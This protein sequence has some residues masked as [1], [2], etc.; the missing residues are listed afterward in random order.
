MKRALLLLLFLFGCIQLIPQNR[1]ESVVIDTPESAVAIAYIDG[2]LLSHP[3]LLQKMQ[4]MNVTAPIGFV[5]SLINSIRLIAFDDG[6]VVVVEPKFPIASSLPTILSIISNITGNNITITEIDYRNFKL[7]T[8]EGGSYFE[9]NNLLYIGNTEKLKLVVDVKNGAKN[10]TEKFKWL[11]GKIPTND[12]MVA[13][14]DV[15]FENITATGAGLNADL[16][17]TQTNHLSAFAFFNETPHQLEFR[18]R[19][20]LSN[21]TSITID[22]LSISEKDKNLSIELTVDLQKLIEEN[23]Q[24]AAK[25]EQQLKACNRK[26]VC[27]DGREFP[28]E[29]FNPETNQCE[30]LAYTGGTPCFNEAG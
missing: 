5:S 12:V 20:H 16:N 2:K 21:I 4:D 19:S 23:E 9:H 26:I 8:F 7:H 27:E 1:L 11:I 24:M 18:I 13:A 3:A 14:A 29:Q 25:T 10:A 6:T 17:P 28:A 30:P 15:P 22:S